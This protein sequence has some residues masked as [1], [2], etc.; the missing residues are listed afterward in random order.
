M[1]NR[2]LR[3]HENAA[4]LK[5]NMPAQKFC[6]YAAVVVDITSCICFHD[7]KCFWAVSSQSCHASVCL[8]AWSYIFEVQT[9]RQVVCI[10]EKDELMILSSELGLFKTPRWLNY[11][12][13]LL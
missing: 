2:F 1:L 12:S 4:R 7:W 3:Q 11:V 13:F 8:C 5:K 9:Q 6:M 10:G